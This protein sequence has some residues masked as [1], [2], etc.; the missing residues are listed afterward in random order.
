MGQ[1]KRNDEVKYLT[2]S[3]FDANWCDRWYY[4]PKNPDQFFCPWAQWFST[5]GQFHVLSK[6]PKNRAFG[7]VNVNNSVSITVRDMGLTFSGA[8]WSS[9]VGYKHFEIKWAIP[10]HIA[11][12][13][14]IDIWLDFSK[15]YIFWYFLIVVFDNA[16]KLFF[17]PHQNCDGLS[18]SLANMNTNAPEVHVFSNV[19][20]HYSMIYT[21]I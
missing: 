7:H 9:A 5:Y 19:I 2:P 13:L 10:R 16:N 18:V 8:E 17:M 1:I 12:W 3:D 4:W 15:K 6:L 11:T 14:K 21:K 20:V